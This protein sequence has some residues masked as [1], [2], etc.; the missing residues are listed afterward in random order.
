MTIVGY[1]LK[2]KKMKLEEAIGQN[3]KHN[4]K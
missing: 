4:E 2:W 1:Q 3:R